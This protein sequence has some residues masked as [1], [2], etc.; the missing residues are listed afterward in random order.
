MNRDGN[1]MELRTREPPGVWNANLWDSRENRSEGKSRTVQD[2]CLE[3]CAVV[4]SLSHVWLFRNPVDC[5]LPASS[6]QEISQARIQE[7][8]I[9]SFPPRIFLT[10]GSNL[11]LLHCSRFF[12]SESPGKPKELCIYLEKKVFFSSHRKHSR[13]IKVL[14]V[15][16]K[17]NKRTTEQK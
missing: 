14:N 16:S 11:R 2:K 13:C 4:K 15:K 3:S 5:S 8:V 6:V 9:S 10:Q 1:R 17:P 12:T 7:W